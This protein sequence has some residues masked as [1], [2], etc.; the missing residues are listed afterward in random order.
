LNSPDFGFLS[1]ASSAIIGT[2]AAFVITNYDFAARAVLTAL[3]L[4][5]P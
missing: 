4:S 5:P 3:F 1:D 2:M